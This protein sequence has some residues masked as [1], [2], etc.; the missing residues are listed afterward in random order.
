MQFRTAFEIAKN[1]KSS[2]DARRRMR[3][4][5]GGQEQVDLTAKAPQSKQKALALKAKAKARSRLENSLSVAI[6]GRHLVT[7]NK[8]VSLI[9]YKGRKCGKEGM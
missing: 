9:K 4:V 7:Q 8:I 6:V 1:Y 3:Q 5:R 2:T